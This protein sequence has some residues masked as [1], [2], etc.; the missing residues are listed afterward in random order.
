LLFIRSA[1]LF[2]DMDHSGC[3]S[4]VGCNSTWMNVV[5]C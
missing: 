5:L 2:I 3:G 4:S 1:V